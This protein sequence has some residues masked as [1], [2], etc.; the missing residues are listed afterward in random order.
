MQWPVGMALPYLQK[1]REE[2][3][4][5]TDKLGTTFC[6]RCEYCLPCPE[7]I[8]I[9]SIFL[10]EGYYTRYGLKEWSMD[11]YLAMEAGPSDC[12][13]CGNVKTN[14]LRTSHQRCSKEPQ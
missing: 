6:R 11:R 4:N 9:P 14:A 8:P 12:T 10:F 5:E 13:E 3:L 2:L 1:E 7:G